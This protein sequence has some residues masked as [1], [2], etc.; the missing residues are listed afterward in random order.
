MTILKKKCNYFWPYMTLYCTITVLQNLITQARKGTKRSIEFGVAY[1]TIKK[2]FLHAKDLR[3]C[4][5]RLPTNPFPSF[6]H[7]ATPPVPMAHSACGGNGMLWQHLPSRN[8]AAL[9]N[10]IGLKL[11]NL[12][13]PNNVLWYTT[14]CKPYIFGIQS[15]S[16]QM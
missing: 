7:R 9:Q 15:A 5:N 2:D 10:N 13:K 3:F 12:T 8:I 1:N 4:W 14:L 11:F 16:K 6:L